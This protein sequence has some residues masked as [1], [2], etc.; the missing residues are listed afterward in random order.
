[1]CSNYFQFNG[2]LVTF[3]AETND[4]RYVQDIIII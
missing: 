3:A 2:I 1:M 4:N